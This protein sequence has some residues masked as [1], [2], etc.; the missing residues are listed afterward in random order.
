MTEKN[1]NPK[2]TE[3]T[4]TG[5]TGTTP[6]EEVIMTATKTDLTTGRNKGGITGRITMTGLGDTIATIATTVTQEVTTDKE[7]T[8]MEGHHQ[9]RA[10]I[11]TTVHRNGE[12]MITHVHN[13]PRMDQEITTI[14]VPDPWMMVPE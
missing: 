14:Q 3:T 6:P 11:A 2:E 5:K 9:D 8:A 10:E 13:I 12:D 1:G 7:E 4:T